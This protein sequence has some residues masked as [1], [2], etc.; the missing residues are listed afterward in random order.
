[1]AMAG[2][3]FRAPTAGDGLDPVSTYGEGSKALSANDYIM[4][5]TTAETR[6][7]E[8]QVEL[9]APHTDHL[10]RLAGLEPG[11]RVLDVGCGLS[12][13]ALNGY[14]VRPGWNR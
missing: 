14:R 11:M 7:L 3:Y 2:E 10:L 1:M 13:V 5:R 12:E 8:I 4:G 6:R 9:Y